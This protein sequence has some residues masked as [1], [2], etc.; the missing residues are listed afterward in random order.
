VLSASPV[1]RA[2]SAFAT[3]LS[4]TSSSAGRCASNVEGRPIR[5]PSAR[6]RSS[7][8]MVRRLIFWASYSAE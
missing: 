2:I 4:S 5:S 7:P 1:R 8:A 3:P 6:A